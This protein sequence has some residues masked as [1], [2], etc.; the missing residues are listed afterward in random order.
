MANNKK[1]A[2]L[3]QNKKRGFS[4]ISIGIIVILTAVIAFM[5]I[6]TIS[7]KP[8]QSSSSIASSFK[9]SPSSGSR[10]TQAE[11]ENGL[12]ALPLSQFDDGKARYFTYAAGEKNINFFVIKSSDGVLRAAFDTCDVCYAAKKGYRQEGD[13]MVC[14]NCGQR[15]PSNLINVEKGGCNPAPLNRKVEGDKLV[16]STADIEQGGWYF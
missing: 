5:I 11:A 2:V 8:D 14:N 4:P 16:I 6:N 1:K 10:F 9:P 3:E 15:F 7:D 13:L 12:V